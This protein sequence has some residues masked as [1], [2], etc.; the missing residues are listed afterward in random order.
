M[1]FLGISILYGLQYEF[2]LCKTV[3]SIVSKIQLSVFQIIKERNKKAIL[4]T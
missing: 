3:N 1:K 2:V 4:A